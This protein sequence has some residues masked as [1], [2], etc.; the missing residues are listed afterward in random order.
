MPSELENNIRAA[1]EKLAKALA[2][3]S[4]VTVETKYVELDPQN[5]EKIDKPFLVA[6]TVIQLDGDQETI[7]PLRR[8][9]TGSLILDEALLDLHLKNVTATT[10]YRKSSIEALISMLPIRGR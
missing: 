9:E 10:E 6:K 7:V 1:A 8:S 4:D 3:A 5:P 2:D